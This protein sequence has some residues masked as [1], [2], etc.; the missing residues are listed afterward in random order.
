MSV[1]GFFSRALQGKSSLVG[2]RFALAGCLASG[3]L[4][5]GCQGDATQE[6]G[7]EDAVKASG[8]STDAASNRAAST[9]PESSSDSTAATTE[10]PTASENVADKVEVPVE[11]PVDQTAP[12]EDSSPR[13][14]ETAAV[15]VETPPR[16]N[17]GVPDSEPVPTEKAPVPSDD[18]ATVLRE[19][20]QA[21]LQSEYAAA[22]TRDEQR[23]L[24]GKLQKLSLDFAADDPVRFMM[25]DEA[26]RFALK[27]ADWR[28]G[29]ELVG[30]LSQK[31]IINQHEYRASAVAQASR[32]A[33]REEAVEVCELAMKFAAEAANA[34]SFDEA[35]QLTHASLAAARRAGSDAPT[36]I[37]VAS[38]K[39]IATARDAFEAAEEARGTLEDKPDDAKANFALGRYLALYRGDWQAALPHLAK[40]D[41]APWRD[42]ARAELD[43]PEEPERLARIGEQWVSLAEKLSAAEQ[44]GLHTHA[45]VWLR[46][47]LPQLS[48]LNQ[49]RI[50]KLLA[51]IEVKDA[52]KSGDPKANS[53]A[54]TSDSSDGKAKNFVEVDT[55]LV[56]GRGGQPFR[57]VV[58]ENAIF[59]GLR[60][61]RTTPISMLQPVFK[62]EKGTEY[63]PIFGEEAE[64]P[65]ELIANPGYK[66]AGLS[67]LTGDFIKGLTVTFAEVRPRNRL[68][69]KWYES[70]Y[71]GE[72]GPGQVT[73]IGSPK[74]PVIGI[75]GRAEVLIDALGL[76]GQKPGTAKTKTEG[77]TGNRKPA[78]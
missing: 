18:E 53:Q 61:S 70:K 23:E 39:E 22:R 71:V 9:N 59:V 65:V 12:A 30:E 37:A 78:T 20:V 14:D 77:S 41:T 17:A 33:D 55:D 26:F 24:A 66:V 75:H 19:K 16:E 1:F 10:K 36:A 29:I 72:V 57:W 32:T 51:T 44:Q 5:C 50:T 31:F 35:T 60:I 74:M 40:S 42:A 34:E 62:S 8:K 56:G 27:S 52:V 3:L 47:A 46:E 11:K 58:P 21:I 48:G 38:S 43:R 2:A 68:R 6:T 49:L 64:K 76:I 13:S 63:G 69:P 4:L 73:R 15:T 7:T 54:G 25:L 67:L 45:A 28:F